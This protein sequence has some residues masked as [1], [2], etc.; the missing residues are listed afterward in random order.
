MKADLK[1]RKQIHGFQRGY[2]C[3]LKLGFKYGTLFVNMIFIVILI[4]FVTLLIYHR[5]TSN[6]MCDSC[7]ASQGKHCDNSMNYK[8][9]FCRGWEYTSI[10]HEMYLALEQKPSD[11]TILPGWRLETMMFDFMHNVFLGTGRDLLASCI[12]CMLRNQ[13]FQ[14]LD[15]VQ[16]DMFAKCRAHGS[17]SEFI[18]FNENVCQPFFEGTMK[19]PY[20]FYRPSPTSIPGCTYRANQCSLKLQLVVGWTTLKCQQ[21]TKQAISKL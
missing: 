7:L 6:R 5:K 15:D 21:G 13:W 8:N 16:N 3:D 4:R 2:N 18:F 20:Y 19:E 9:F 1:A 12:H 14:S 10:D 11:W 17:L